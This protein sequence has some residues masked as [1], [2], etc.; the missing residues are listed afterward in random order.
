MAGLD[1]EEYSF[2]EMSF[3]CS[4]FIFVIPVLNNSRGGICCRSSV[5]GLEK[6]IGGGN[7][8]H[9]LLRRAILTHFVQVAAFFG[10]CEP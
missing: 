4:S 7:C 6:T 2:V 10:M 1:E 8:L 5:N 3:P 9:A